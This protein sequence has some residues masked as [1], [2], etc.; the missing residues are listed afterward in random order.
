MAPGLEH[1]K[2]IDFAACY[3]KIQDGDTHDQHRNRRSTAEKI[4]VDLSTLSLFLQFQ[5]L[6]YVELHAFI[7]CRGEEIRKRTSFMIIV[8]CNRLGR[9]WTVARIVASCPKFIYL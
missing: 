9:L 4:S 2:P 8:C 5:N 7:A 6:K 1:C 3:L